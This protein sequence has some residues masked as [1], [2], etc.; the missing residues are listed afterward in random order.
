[1]ARKKTATPS[2]MEART[3]TAP[4]VPRVREA[5]KAWALK[6]YPGATATSERLLRFW[7]HQSHRP[8]GRKFEY[9]WAQRESVETLVYLF[10]VAKVRSQA[11]LLEQ[12]AEQQNLKLLQTDDFTRYC[13]KMATGSGKTKV[14]SLAVA[15]QYLNAVQGEGAEYAKT[16]LIIAPNVIVFERLRADF[17]GGYVFRTDPVIPAEFRPY[18]D[19]QFYMRGEAERGGSEGALYLTNVQQLHERREVE[20]DEPDAMAAMLGP[21]PPAKTQAAEDFAPR[22]ARRGGPVAVLNDEAHHLHDEELTWV[23]GIARLHAAT[24]GGVGMQLD[25]SATPRHK[26]G[27]LFSWTVFDYPLKQ[28]ILDGIVKRPVKGVTKG[29]GEASSDIAS[30]RYQTYLTAGVQRW[31]EYRDQLAPLKRKPLLFVMMNDTK[32]ADEVGDWLRRTYPE[33]FGGDRSLV[34]HTNR[35]GEVSKGDLDAARQAARDVDKGVSPVNAVVSV[36]MLRE[37]WDV[38]GVTVIVGLR[39]FTAKANI[40]PEQTIGRGLRLMFRDQAL[41]YPGAGGGREAGYVER[42]DIIGNKKFLEVLE[43]LEK[44]EDYQLEEVDLDKDKVVIET[45]FPDP[46]K[47]AMDIA[48]PELTP[49]LVRKKSLEAEIAG[50]ALP[51]LDKPLPMKETDAGAKDFRY[52]GY[53][54]IEMKKLFDREYSIPTPQT[55]EEVIGYYAKR[56]AQDVKLPSQFAALVPRVREFLE[57]VAFGRPVTLDAPEMVKAIASNYANFVTVKAFVKELRKVVVDEQVPELVNAGRPLSETKGF[58]WSRPTLK[59]ASKCVFNLVPCGNKYELRF[60]K[61]LQGADDVARFAKL[62]ERFGFVIEYTDAM[63]SLRHYEPDFVAV[64]TDGVNRL[65]ETKGLEDTNVAHK[66]RAAVQWCENATTLTGKPWVYLKVR[67]F[68][69]DKLQPDCVGDLGALTLD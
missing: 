7:F 61:F 51:A 15:W 6:G 8:G 31:R 27:Q 19:V 58:P 32:D 49:I 21:K 44:D 16:F 12:F 33:D 2:F 34:I 23:E 35:Q 36:V 43:Q 40:L 30:V 24:A 17:E 48:M 64:T 69:F 52:E 46:D 59:G 57:R 37:G 1:M 39:P 5:V 45:V 54:L 55:A 66:D 28:A 3:T 9:H 62:P 22:I 47:L 29:M 67:E 10:E 60:A 11:A 26:E 20:A 50:M 63:G 14:M 13:V 53:D 38:Q 18:W 4:C 65:L 41:A 42:V 56:I 68:E 25:F